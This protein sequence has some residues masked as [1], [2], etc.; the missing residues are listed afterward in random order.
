MIW[1]WGVCLAEDQEA[2]FDPG[3]LQLCL[4]P[5]SEVAFLRGEVLGPTQHSPGGLLQTFLG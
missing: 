2:F 5:Q 1:I 4:M 3:G